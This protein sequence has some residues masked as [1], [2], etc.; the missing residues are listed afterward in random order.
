MGKEP[1]FSGMPTALVWY[2]CRSP[3]AFSASKASGAE[4]QKMST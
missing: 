3:L 2:F 1:I 4:A